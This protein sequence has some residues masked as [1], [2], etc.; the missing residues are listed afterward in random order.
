MSDQQTLPAEYTAPITIPPRP[1]P[2]TPPTH[3][4]A[5]AAMDALGPVLLEDVAAPA[6][7]YINGCRAA[8]GE[9]P[10]SVGEVGQ[11]LGAVALAV[12]AAGTRAAELEKEAQQLRA[13]LSNAEDYLRLTHAY[14]AAGGGHD[15]LGADFSC[16]GC[17]LAKKLKAAIDTTDTWTPRDLDRLAEDA[18][19]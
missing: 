10:L 8:C 15:T 12:R 2:F 18:R 14:P 6:V 1:T 16:D 17:V 5:R 11:V 4:E 3:A 19:P 7:N 9:P 13:L